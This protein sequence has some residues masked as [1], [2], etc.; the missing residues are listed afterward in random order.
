[1]E[2]PAE[3][4]KELEQFRGVVPAQ[5]AS[6]IETLLRTYEKLDKESLNICAAKR[7]VSPAVN[8]LIPSRSLEGL[9][10]RP[11]HRSHGGLR[12][13]HVMSLVAKQL[14]EKLFNAR[15]A[16]CRLPSGCGAISVAL[17][18]LTNLRANVM[19]LPRE[20]TTHS[21]HPS[22]REQGYGGFR[23]LQI[24]D[25][26]LTEDR[27]NVDV[28]AMAEVAKKV[29]PSLIITGSHVMLFPEP[30][31]EIRKIA[32]DIGAK[33][34]YDGAHVLGLIAGRKFQ[35]PL[36]DGVDLLVGSTH[37][38][39]SGPQGGIILTNKDEMI[40]RLEPKMTGS[41]M[42]S[43]VSAGYVAGLAVTLAEWL[44]FGEEFAD[45]VVRNAK[46]LGK[47]MDKEGFHL[48][49]K[50][51]G[52]TES[53]TVVA[54]ISTLVK[55]DEG[56]TLLEGAGIMAATYNL[57]WEPASKRGC[58]RMGTTIPTRY[59][60]KES[61]MK[62]IARFLRRTLIDREAPEN[63]RRDVLDF[64]SRF[65]EIEYCFK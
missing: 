18:S 9:I 39:L 29:K 54:E 24:T 61:E 57:W 52:Y 50:D 13:F 5:I 64:K 12:Y 34:M 65:T 46:A 56:L 59:G 42:H 58:L 23:G 19:A 43:V 41:R 10:S 30:I 60:M 35:D 40:E 55:G 37:K 3:Y 6:R 26:P 27:L 20:Y 21:A 1:M 38:T 47:A 14:A 16:E 36:K 33:M 62:E 44:E 53:H 4:L 63:V 28:D 22:L 15:F 25:I 31:A 17:Y 2:I 45:Q 11:T 49:G 7:V 51:K 8:R 48:F 32:D